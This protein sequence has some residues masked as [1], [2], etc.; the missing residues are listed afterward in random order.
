MRANIFAGIIKAVRPEPLGVYSI[1]FLVQGALCYAL[2]PRVSQLKP[3]EIA[4]LLLVFFFGFDG[5]IKLDLIE[6]PKKK[7]T[8]RFRP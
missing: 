3:T 6:A 7:L 5:R 2:I 8:D 4:S 1:V